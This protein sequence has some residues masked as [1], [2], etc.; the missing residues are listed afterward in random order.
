MGSFRKQLLLEIIEQFGR[1]SF[2]FKEAS[3]LPSFNRST[4]MSLYQDGLIKKA[5]PG[6]PLRYSIISR[7]FEDIRK[8]RVK[9][10]VD[11]NCQI[12]ENIAGGGGIC[13]DNKQV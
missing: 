11:G 9:S 6:F 12:V 2:T 7:S 10:D 13:C 3:T 1:A 5:S 4:F 8:Q